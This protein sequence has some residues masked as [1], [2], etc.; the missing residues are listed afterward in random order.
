MQHGGMRLPGPV[1]GLMSLAAK[2][3]TKSVYR[4]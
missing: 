2:V 3:M 4:I 1:R